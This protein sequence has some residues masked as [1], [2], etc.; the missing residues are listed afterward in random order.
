MDKCEGV[1]FP[2]APFKRDILATLE[3]H[4]RSGSPARMQKTGRGHLRHTPPTR[5]GLRPGSLHPSRGLATAHRPGAKNRAT[6]VHEAGHAL[7]AGLLGVRVDSVSLETDPPAAWVY[8]RG[9]FAM[10]W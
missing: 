3:E 1:S 2:P 10:R 5:A 6:S 7:V 4:V 9:A 8:N